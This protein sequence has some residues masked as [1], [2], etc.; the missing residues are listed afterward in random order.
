M[1][2]LVVAEHDN[3][4]LKAGTLNT[5]TAAAACGDEI[6]ILVAGHECKAVAQAA[7]AVAGVSRVM[8]ADAPHLANG[9]A[10][11]LAEQVLALAGDY[12]HILVPASTF[13]KNV[14]PRVAARLDVA[15]ISEAIQIDAPDTFERAI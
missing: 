3:A 10:E 12:S 8:V 1:A 14:M 11:N 13:G 7:A 9:L 6:H 4:V 15:Q 2:V 5:V